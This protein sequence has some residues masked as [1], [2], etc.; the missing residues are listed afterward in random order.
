MFTDF[1]NYKMMKDFSAYMLSINHATQ[2]VA[3]KSAGSDPDLKTTGTALCM[4]NGE[5]IESLTAC[6]TIDLSDVAVCD[7]AGEVIGD[8]YEQYWLVVAKGSD[9]TCLVL[10]ASEITLTS[11]GAELKIPYYDPTVYVPIGLVK[12]V[13]DS[14]SDFTIGTTNVD[15]TDAQIT[16]LTM[17]PIVPHT[18]NL[19]K[20]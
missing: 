4:V 13:N 19:D 5:L 8:G 17:L 3:A 7:Q 18:D 12:Y 2:A 10:G 6:A 9:G 14:G 16:Q 15:G 11:S 20:N 1:F